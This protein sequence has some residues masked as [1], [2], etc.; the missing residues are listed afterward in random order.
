MLVPVITAVLNAVFCSGIVTQD[1][2]G[3]LITPVFEKG[4]PLN[5]ANYRPIAA[6]EP[7][8]RLYAG[9]LNAGIVDFS[10]SAGLRAAI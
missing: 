8:M 5:T 1:I 4:H 2:K 6:T 7:I 3:A 9:I 10:E